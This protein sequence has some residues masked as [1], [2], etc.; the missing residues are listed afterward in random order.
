[1]EAS[2]IIVALG[3]DRWLSRRTVESAIDEYD[4]ERLNTTRY[5]SEEDP[6]DQVV[7][8]AST[9][10]FF[11]SARVIVATG[12]MPRENRAAPGA[13]KP[14]S[15][16][17]RKKREN[18]IETL[19]SASEEAGCV[20]ILHEPTR[21]GLPS[22]LKNALTS[23]ARVVPG[24][25]PRGSALVDL[26]MRGFERRGVHIDRDTVR[27]LLSTLFPGQWE[28]KPSNAAYDRPPDLELLINEVE[29][30]ALAAE[31]DIL[32][33][34]VVMQMVMQAAQD[35]TFPIIDSVLAGI[36]REALR[37]LE[38][39]PP[40]DDERL[41]QLSQLYQTMEYVSATGQA[42][43]PSDPATTAQQLGMSNPR[44]IGPVLRA[45]AAMPADPDQMLLRAREADF[46]LK[47]GID[48]SP[49]DAFYRLIAAA[50]KRSEAKT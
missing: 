25:P 31:D 3:P 22:A 12:Y 27:L 14:R 8:A 45:L 34:D 42:G 48:P 23:D 41:R 43:R 9:P 38:G 35:R 7:A 5:S 37:E 47:R 44:R 29:K 24:E 11:G 4:A 10:S 46:R 17:T 15:Q 18:P 19:I 20:L 26:V 28:Q 30:L 39:L 33:A 6:F 49:L 32:T 2:V 50:R 1:M 16:K 21:A 40:S 36:Q 13:G